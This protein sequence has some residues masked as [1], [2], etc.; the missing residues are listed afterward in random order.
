M[1][2]TQRIDANL[3]N[4]LMLVTVLNP[5]IGYEKAAR[6]ALTTHREGITLRAAALRLGDVTAGQFDAWVRPEETHPLAE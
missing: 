2:D 5:H 3:N 1:P 4:S 6:I